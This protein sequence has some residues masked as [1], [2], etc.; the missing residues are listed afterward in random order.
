MSPTSKSSAPPSP[1]RSPLK[2]RWQ[3]LSSRGSILEWLYLAVG[4]CLIFRYRWLFDDSHIYYRYVDNL[5][6]LDAGLTYNAGEF[7]EGFSS[8]LHCLVLVALRSLHLSYPIISIVMGLGLFVVFWRL[9]VEL[10]RSLGPSQQEVHSLNFPLVFMA[11]NYSVTSFFTSGNETALTHVAAAATALFIA[12][13]TSRKLAVLVAASPLVRPEL[14]LSLVVTMVYAWWRTRRFP[15]PL[16][17]WSALLNGAW[18]TFRVYYYAELLPNTFYL[19]HG[20]NFAAG[21]RYLLDTVTP[22]HL[23]VILLL[24]VLM[25]SFLAWRLNRVHDRGISPLRLA[26]RAAML[27]SALGITAYVIRTGGSAMHYYYLAAPLTLTLCSL[28]GLSEIAIAASECS[29]ASTRRKRWAQPAMVAFAC[30]ALCLYPPNLDQHPISGRA[31]MLENPS[32]TI[33]TDP[34]FF[35]NRRE[36]LKSWPLIVDMVAFAPKLKSEGYKQWTRSTWCDTIH[37][38]YEIRSI[39]GYGLT[40]GILARADVPEKKRGHKPALRAMAQK[41]IKIQKA[42]TVIDRGMYREAVMR[43]DAP[44]WV[45]KNLETLELIELKIY[46][47]HD[48][49]ENLRLALRRTPQINLD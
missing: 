32:Q 25:T 35:K 49:G 38:D 29:D 4:L 26:P 5:L 41:I 36:H 11:T 46:N 21:W 3:L 17:L 18:L 12:R 15:T 43:G 42:A 8:P 20:S 1:A 9:L 27:V 2:R 33:I 30:L 48:L 22:Y 23:G 28:A 16:V 24:F 14:A 31:K 37:S 39:H 10:G 44:L 45:V 34:A 13:P 40:D 47:R 19:K 6:F 7:V